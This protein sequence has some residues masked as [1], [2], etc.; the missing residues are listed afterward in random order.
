MNF[1]DALIAVKADRK[2]ARSGWNGK[3]MWIGLKRPFTYPA[4][5]EPT[6]PYLYIEYPKGHP[7]Y[8]NGSLVPWLASQTDI[9]AED[10]SILEET[11]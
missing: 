6:H 10:W 5:G 7:A 9:L 8:P 4:E 3:N 1:G 11:K 2:I